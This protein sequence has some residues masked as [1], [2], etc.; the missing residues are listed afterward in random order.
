MKLEWTHSIAYQQQ[1]VQIHMKSHLL[2]V[3]YAGH[4]GNKLIKSRNKLIKS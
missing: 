3:P 2:V 4:K 1:K